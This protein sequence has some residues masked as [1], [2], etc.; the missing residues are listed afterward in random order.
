[1]SAKFNLI[2]FDFSA[3]YLYNIHQKAIFSVQ[4]KPTV[5]K[6]NLIEV[7]KNGL[8]LGMKSE[9]SNK[10]KKRYIDVYSSIKA[11]DL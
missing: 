4:F 1:M 11:T 8:P 9:Y 10:V 7:N 2:Q 6:H 5:V 3:A